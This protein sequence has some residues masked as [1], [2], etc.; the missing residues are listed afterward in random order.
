MT[1]YKAPEK[2]LN[3][4]L[5][6]LFDAPTIWKTMPNYASIDAD[7]CRA[8]IEGAAKLAENDLAPLSANGDKVGVRLQD[9]DVKT[10]EGFKQAYQNYCAGGWAGIVGDV[11]YNGQGL[12]HA[13]NLLLGEIFSASNTAFSLYTGLT[14]GAGMAMEEHASEEIKKRYLSK[15]YQGVWS[16]CMCLTESHAG[17]DLGLLRTKAEP[18][19][20]GSY[21]LSGTKIFI[22]AGD[23]DLTDNIIYLV[24]A[25]TPDAPK[26]IK[27]ISLF[28][29]SKFLVDKDDNL[30]K[31]NSV[32]CDAVEDKMGIHASSTCVMR[33]DKAKAYLVG[34]PNKGMQAMFSMMN[35]ER[36]MVG[37]QGI[38]CAEYAYQKARAYAA[39]RRQGRSAKGSKA[40][41]QGADTIIVHPDVRRMLM[42]QKAFIEGSRA[43]ATYLSLQLDISMHAKDEQTR[44]AA[45]NR[46]AL[47]TPVV[48]GF[49]TDKGFECCVMAQ[50][51]FGGHGYIRETGV[52]Q[53]VR[54]VRISQIYEG[55]NGVQA[56][57]LVYRKTILN[58]C[59]WINNLSDE[60]DAYTKIQASNKDMDMYVK[61]LQKAVADLRDTARWIV[62]SAMKDPDEA[63]AASVDY[64]HLLGYVVLAWMWCRQAEVAHKHMDKD[65][66]YYQGKLHVAAFYMTRLLPQTDSLIR[67]IKSSAKHMMALPAEA[68]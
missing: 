59:E 46:V 38:A 31:R 4:V 62:D 35:H 27:G 2:D 44:L 64:M 61:P 25:R 67:A 47:L 68:F 49:C 60:I 18:E 24:L 36:I 48:K 51:V 66:K 21:L 52:E 57:D 30:G 3:F 22:T 23:H 56:L 5:D 7:T 55:T 28:L 20:D 50:Q 12:P 13:L 40:P 32:Y 45:D 14:V 1:S 11:R 37:L 19:A 39:E 58:N 42:T 63:G 41:D 33:F 10:P 34:A 15:M 17:T 65:P 8:L 6:E 53:I 9:G 26:G 43:F 54:D 29:V 16:A